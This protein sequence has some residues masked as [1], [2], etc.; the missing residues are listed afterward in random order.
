MIYYDEF[1]RNGQLIEDITRHLRGVRLSIR[2]GQ[3]LMDNILRAMDVRDSN[4]LLE[5]IYDFIQFRRRNDNVGSLR[6][7]SERPRY[8]MT[9]E[10]EYQKHVFELQ[11]ALTKKETEL[12][13]KE[14]EL[15]ARQM[16]LKEKSQDF[17][18]E[19]ECKIE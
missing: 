2:E 17:L 8:A 1:H 3:V 5:E 9:P 4:M 14:L 19:E 7:M 12:K 16:I 15:Q 13:V 11:L 6:Q 10:E 18:S